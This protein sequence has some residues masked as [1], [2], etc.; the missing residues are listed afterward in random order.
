MKNFWNKEKIILLLIILLGGFLR[1]YN[2]NWDQGYHLHPDERAI[3]MF[4]TPLSFPSSIKEFLTESSPLNPH[5]F[6]YGSFPIYLLKAAGNLASNINSLYLYYEKLNLVGRFLSAFFDIGTLL[7]IYLLGKKLFNT[8]VALIGAFF[9]GISVLPIQLSHFYAVDTI[10]TFFVLSTLYQSI[11]LYEKPTITKSLLVGFFFGLSLATKIS[12]IAL[13]SAIS[14][15]LIVDFLLIF[16]KNPHRPRIWFPH[17]PKFLK[18]LI[19]D[20]L[21]ITTVTVITFI[22][23]EPYAVIDSKTFWLHNM[24]QRQM[25]YDAFTF[26]YTLQYVG[27]I[28]YLYEL[29]NI[30]LWG[31]GPIVSIL[32][33][34]GVFYIIFL[35]FK[36]QK[37]N[38][39]A[40]ELILLTFLVAYFAVV[41]N[42]AIGFM[43][44]LLPLYPL[45]S[46]FG[47]VFALRLFILITNS[48]I[49]QFSIFNFQFSNKSKKLNFKN[50]NIK[51]SIKI[52]NFKFQIRLLVVLVC[53]GSI[54]VWPLSFMHIYT[55]PN[56]RVQATNW[57]NQNIPY[58]ATLA[59]EHWDDGLPLFGQ[60]NY[61]IL[62]LELYNPDTPDKWQIINQ[63]LSQTDYILI[64][65]NR[66]YV[67]L[68]KLTDCQKLPVGRCYTQT[69]EYYKRLFSG[70]NVILNSFQGLGSNEIP[71][72]VRNDNKNIVSF[73]KVAEF[74]MYPTIPILNIPINDEITDES[75]TVYDHPKIMIFKKK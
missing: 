61:R 11:R 71:K 56:T 1:F 64:A 70:Q 3:V 34:S 35:I 46:L 65:S 47:A 45:F 18:R 59:I 10:L 31:Q 58:G 32:S 50:Y 14:A 66:L 43:R 40:Q 12:A 44:Y 49:G 13:I 5:F 36:K 51:N 25:T 75:F 17:V 27:K 7:T 57:I 37:I 24:Q 19:I 67:P 4:T 9:Y 23:F 6:A 16:I 63:Q 26:P 30:F 55:K 73:Q 2:L 52:S 15:V 62:T 38:K 41:G 29:K 53:V 68:M 21:I 69:A 54:F 72:Q 48:N 33:I 8:K 39:W 20:G 60:Q 42:F 74:S 22:V 28:P